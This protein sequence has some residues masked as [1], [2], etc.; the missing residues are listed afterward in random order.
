MAQAARVLI[1]L[2]RARAISQRPEPLPPASLRSLVRR[3]RAYVG[4]VSCDRSTFVPGP[5]ASAI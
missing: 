5:G 1:N 2:Q 4:V 3:P